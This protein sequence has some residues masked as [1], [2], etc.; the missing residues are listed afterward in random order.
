MMKKIFFVF[1]FLLTTF[2][3]EAQE[4]SI[5]VAQ[6]PA[7]SVVAR[8]YLVGGLSYVP[9][10]NLSTSLSNESL[11]SLD[12]MTIRNIGIGL[13]FEYRRFAI[14]SQICK[15][16]FKDSENNFNYKLNGQSISINLNYNLLEGKHFG[17]DF[18]ILGNFSNSNLEIY[19]KNS[20]IDLNN[21]S[22]SAIQTN[23]LN[24]K[25]DPFSLG[26]SIGVSM[27]ENKNS[28]VKITFSYQ[29]VMNR[30]KW[31]SEYATVLNAPNE[32]GQNMFSLTSRIYFF[33]KRSK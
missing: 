25:N 9:S 1:L 20:S 33:S 12:K 6:K 28:Q 16:A 31:D 8:G 24:L 26:T 3:S 2:Y 23:S 32:R 22:S 7:S 27:L 29:R 21:L 15:I 10:F 14:G 19:S 4:D 30:A 17:L 11:F 5:K 18:G 13:Q